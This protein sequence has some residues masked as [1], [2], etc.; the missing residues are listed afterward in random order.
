MN[1]F[2]QKYKAISSTAQN[3]N[4]GL[5]VN[6]GGSQVQVQPFQ[7]VFPLPLAERQYNPKLTQ[8]EGY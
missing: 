4:N 3:P 1:A 2:Y 5:F 7:V 6:S 8:N